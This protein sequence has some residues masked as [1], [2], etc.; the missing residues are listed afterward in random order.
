[1]LVVTLPAVPAFAA[2]PPGSECEK[3]GLQRMAEDLHLSEAQLARIGQIRSDARQARAGFNDTLR[4][5][6]E[7]MA[8]LDPEAG[9][10]MERMDKLTAEKGATAR[11]MMQTNASEQAAISAVLTPQQRRWRTELHTQRQKRRRM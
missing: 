9:D 2:C 3:N 5:N 8:A 10:Y 7:A 6:R 4:A 1:M 11:A